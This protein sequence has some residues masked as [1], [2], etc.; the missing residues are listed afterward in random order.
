MFE[1]ELQA[2]ENATSWCIEHQTPSERILIATD[3]QSLCHA[4]L[5]NGATTQHLKKQL[6]LCCGKVIIQWIPCHAE[7]EGNELADTAAK[8]AATMM[9]DEP[10]PCSL[11]GILPAINNAIVD[12]PFTHARS[13]NSYK[14]YSRNRE[15][16]LPRKDQVMLARIRS[17]HS[18]LFRA[19]KHRIAK[20]LDPYCK[21]CNTG[22]EDTVEHWLECDSTIDA[23]MRTF[24]YTR[25]ELG[26]LTRWPRE[27]VALAR[28]TLF[29]GAEQS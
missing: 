9:H 26:D 10:R 11:H 22:K 29:R 19:Y 5:G 3:S 28:K 6:E 12:P 16:L 2:L 25:L 4:L 27:S 21:R 20:S 8:E 24:G 14:H 17:G 15:K 1:E 18:L 7:V 13:K 23:R